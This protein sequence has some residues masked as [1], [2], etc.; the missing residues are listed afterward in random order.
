MKAFIPL[1]LLTV[2]TATPKPQY[3]RYQRALQNLPSQAGQTC[4]VL[5]PNIFPHAAEGLA[6]LRLYANAP[7]AATLHQDDVETPYIVRSIVSAPSAPGANRR[8]EQGCPNM[9]K[10][11]SM[12]IFRK[13]LTATLISI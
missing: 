12:P 8:I 9:A 1:L 5:A 3:F 4:V 13:A 2:A 10:P 6:D 11:S 7:Q